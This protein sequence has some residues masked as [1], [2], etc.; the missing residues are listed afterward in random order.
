MYARML[1]AATFKSVFGRD[2]IAL[3]ATAFQN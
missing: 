2:L 1:D 3:P